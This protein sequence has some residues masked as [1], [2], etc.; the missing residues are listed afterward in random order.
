M[1]RW[2]IVW[3]GSPFCLRI[4]SRHFTEA[5][6]SLRH[7]FTNWDRSEVMTVAEARRIDA[8]IAERLRSHTYSDPLIDRWWQ[9]DA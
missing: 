9:V 5:G 6:A 3:D 2:C 8:L 7:Y 4:D 1:R